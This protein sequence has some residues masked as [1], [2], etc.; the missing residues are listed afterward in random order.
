MEKSQKN[1]IILNPLPSE[2]YSS[3]EYGERPFA[4]L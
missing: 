3:G 4:P 1:S 2:I